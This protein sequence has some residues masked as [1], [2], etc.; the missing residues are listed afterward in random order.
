MDD[1]LGFQSKTISKRINSEIPEII[2]DPKRAIWITDIITTGNISLYLEDGVNVFEIGD[3]N[4]NFSHS[5]NGIFMT[6]RDARVVA[7]GNG[8]VLL[9]C[10]PL[11]NGKDY[12]QWTYLNK[13][14]GNYG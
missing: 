13:I 3:F 11:V 4:G 14:G 12:T 2:L 8:T 9:T 1:Q 10:I 6:W 5:F 7:K